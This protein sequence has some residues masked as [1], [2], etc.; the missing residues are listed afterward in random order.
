VQVFGAQVLMQCFMSEHW[1]AQIRHE[2]MLLRYSG[3]ALVTCWGCATKVLV[4][5]SDVMH[6]DEAVAQR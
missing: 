5:D 4:R 1:V 3:C 2:L 6:N